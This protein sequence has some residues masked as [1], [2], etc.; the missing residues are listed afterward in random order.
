MEFIEV[1]GIE[2]IPMGIWLVKLDTSR[3]HKNKDY[4]VLYRHENVSIVGGHFHFDM[5]PIV[6]YHPV[7][8]SK[9]DAK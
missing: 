7:D 1:K 8:L 6:A 2:E 9:T 5:P 3:R 4:Q